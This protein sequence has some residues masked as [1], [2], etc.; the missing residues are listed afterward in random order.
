MGAQ[1]SRLPRL[2]GGRP[3]AG[4]VAARLVALGALGV[5]TVIVARTGGPAEVGAYALLR[6]LPGLAGVL[7]SCGLP[8]AAPYFLAG[9]A[10]PRLRPTIVALTL[11]AGTL[12][13]LGWLALTPVL[14]RVFFPNLSG[15]LVALAGVAVFTQLLVAV[16]KAQLQGGEDLRGANVA[17]AMEE[18]AFLPVYA[19]LLPLLDGAGLL[20]VALIG[21]DVVVAAGI[22]RRLIRRGYLRGWARPSVALGRRITS[23]GLRGQVGSL[24]GLLN[25]R[26]DFALLGA[27]AGPAV[28]G[29]YAVASKYAELLRL[30]GLAVT[31]VLYPRFARTGAA[32]AARRTAA[33]LPRAAAGNALAAL[34]LAAAAGTVLPLLYGP[35]FQAALLPAYILLGGL[36][37]EGVAG[38]V[39]AYLYG[40]GRPGLNSVAMGVGLV[41]TGVLDLLL[42]P[43][44]GAVGAAIASAAAYAVTTVA[45]LGCF[46]WLRRSRPVLAAPEPAVAG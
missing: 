18:A 3:L 8:A 28:L 40:D 21:A 36:A 5:A 1:V 39:T 15:P 6:V 34:V 44:H 27:L 42:I 7:V 12:A 29:S 16:G 2:P 9:R 25:L 43:R 37:G 11:L 32:A 24:L 30:P 4:N 46:A 31:Y 19:A 26:L 17:I 10:D 38:L 23:F 22:W 35:Q 45:L 14:E 41:L 33:L 20:I 13:A